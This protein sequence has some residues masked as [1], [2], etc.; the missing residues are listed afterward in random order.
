MTI[1]QRDKTISHIHH[2]PKLIEHD[3]PVNFV[4]GQILY[5]HESGQYKLAYASDFKPSQVIGV[6]WSI[7]DDRHFWLKCEP[8]PMSYR[9]PFAKSYF[10]QIGGVVQENNSTL[11]GQMG[12]KLWLS[13]T[14]P[15]YVQLV[16]PTYPTLVG[17]RTEYGMIYRPD[18]TSCCVQTGCA[19]F[20]TA[21]NDGGFDWYGNYVPSPSWRIVSIAQTVD[22]PTTDWLITGSSATRTVNVGTYGLVCDLDAAPIINPPEDS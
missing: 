14:V 11:P 15:G 18:I 22:S 19:Y 16:K 7:V 9:F 1:H 2:D 10:N 8:C 3:Y 13:E 12:V 21:Q 6:V 5:M 20:Y 4:P 17:Y